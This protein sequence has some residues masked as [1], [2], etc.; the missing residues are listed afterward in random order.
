L[1][2]KPSHCFKPFPTIKPSVIIV[3]AITC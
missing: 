1:G 3:T 2:A